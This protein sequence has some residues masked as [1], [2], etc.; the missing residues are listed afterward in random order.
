VLVSAASPL[1]HLQVR[2]DNQADD[3][4][5]RLRARST[6][7]TLDETVDALGHFTVVERPLRHAPTEVVWR[8]PPTQLDH[9][10]GAVRC[11]GVLLAGRGIHE[12]E[13]DAGRLELTV[14]RSVG[15]LSR[16]DIAGRPGNAGP[17]IA[18]PDAQCRGPLRLEL[19]VGIG[20][21]ASFTAARAFLAGPLLL[22]AFDD[23][24]CQHPAPD[25]AGIAIRESGAMARARDVLAVTPGDPQALLDELGLELGGTGVHVSALKLAEDGSGDLVARWWAPAGAAGRARVRVSA[26]V[27]A[28]HRCRLDETPLG[29]AP[30]QDGTCEVTVAA[31]AIVSLRIVLDR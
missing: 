26:P 18:T 9:C 24:Q 7:I 27:R 10:A 4:R 22:E 11:G 29:P 5:L 17:A 16:R 3:H 6:A 25:P 20:D 21:A 1:A 19:A 13:A 31:G 12:Y 14:L 8:Q 30:L 28:I 23:V 2:L 15:W